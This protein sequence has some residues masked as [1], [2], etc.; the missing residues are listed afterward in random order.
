MDIK[1]F[2]CTQDTSNH[3]IK[4]RKDKLLMDGIPV[5]VPGKNSP[6]APKD[7][8]KESTEWVKDI[9]SIQEASPKDYNKNTFTHFAAVIFMPMQAKMVYD[10]IAGAHVFSPPLHT[11]YAYNISKAVTVN[12]SLDPKSSTLIFREDDQE[13]KHH[14][15]W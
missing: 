3:A 14:K 2:L 13:W 10:H 6:H 7:K 11:I 12:N 9:L 5:V 8:P 1:L 4:I 15:I